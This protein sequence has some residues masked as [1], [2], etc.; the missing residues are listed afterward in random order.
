MPKIS[1][2]AMKILTADT[3]KAVKITTDI[4]RI[5]DLPKTESMKRAVK[6]LLRKIFS[7]GELRRLPRLDLDEARQ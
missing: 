6:T 1:L 5:P 4:D 7:E 3:M 2:T